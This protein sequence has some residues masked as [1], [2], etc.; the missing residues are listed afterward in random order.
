MNKEL[1]REDHKRQA[2]E[3]LDFARGAGDALY[4][5][6]KM[7]EHLKQCNWTL[8]DIGTSEEDLKTVTLRH[9]QQHA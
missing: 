6:E 8:A 5:I 2:K 4:G 9:V 1:S 3:W 7:H